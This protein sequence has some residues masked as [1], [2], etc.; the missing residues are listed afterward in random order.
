[1]IIYSIAS[2]KDDQLNLLFKCFMTIAQ[3]HIAIRFCHESAESIGANLS[4]V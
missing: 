2:E 1:M 4:S 3:I